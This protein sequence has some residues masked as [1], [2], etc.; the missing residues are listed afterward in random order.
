[1]VAAIQQR[2]W[3]IQLSENTSSTDIRMI[4]GAVLE[5]KSDED[6]MTLIA[7]N[8]TPALETLYNRHVRNCFGLAMKIVRDPH[9]AEEV[10]Q[11]V[12]VKLWSKPS[13]F[14][15]ERGKFS[16]WLLTLVHNRS[17]D[18]LRRAS[19]GLAGLTVTLDTDSASGMSLADI[20]PDESPSLD[21]AAWQQERGE[22]LRKAMRNLP[23][24]QR[25]ALSLA[26]FGGLTQKEIADRLHE[27][28]G[29]IKTR[30]R[31]GLQHLRRLLMG[32][33]IE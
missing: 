31:S 9:V 33:G 10:V 27:P 8:S 25:Q 4:A 22:I 11:D 6:L 16:G 32:A 3:N 13:I 18:K 7:Q 17:V 1:M 15:P 5:H 28:L 20:L 21:D 30:T 19:A 26:Y 2:P 14:M 29:T 12:F 23:L 24:P